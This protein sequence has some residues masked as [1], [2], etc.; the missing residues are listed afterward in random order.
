M[1]TIECIKTRRSCRKYS[2]RKVDRE[3]IDAAIAAAAYAPSWKNTQVTRY[4]VVEDAALKE[5]VAK[6]CCSSNHNGGIIMEAPVLIA[7]TMMRNR[8]GY[9]RD[10]SFSTTKEKGWQMFD[11]GIATQTLCLALHDAGVDTL[12]MGILDIEKATELLNIPE[13][14]E[15]AALIAVGYRA[16]EEIPTPPKKTLEQLVTYKA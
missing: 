2:D 14:Q 3:V 10:G 7:T 11:C 15:I 4:I 8:S 13:E 6:E 16:D 9:E 12:I 1:E 5:Q